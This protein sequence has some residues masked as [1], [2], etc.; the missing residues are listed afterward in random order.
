[1]S[2]PP[3]RI[4]LA[5]FD[6][7]G[8]IRASGGATACTTLGSALARAGHQV[9][10]VY[11]NGSHC[12]T[13][14]PESWKRHFAE[15]GIEFVPLEST[16]GVGLD[17]THYVTRSHHA[18]DWLKRREH[19]VVHFMDF[20]GLGYFSLRAKRQG[21]AFAQTRLCVSVHGPFRWTNATPILRFPD[22]QTLE[23]D[24]LERESIALA[25]ELFCPSRALVSWMRA[26]GWT[27]PERV[28]VQPNLLPDYARRAAP[29]ENGR[30]IGEVVF[31][32]RLEDVKGLPEFCDALDRLSDAGSTPDLKVTFLGKDGR[33]DGASG[34]AC[35]AR[36]AVHWTFP[37]RHVGDLDEARAVDYLR[38]PGRLAVIPSRRENSPYAVLECLAAGVPFLASRVGGVPELIARED[39]DRVTFAP[40]AKSMATKI[41]ECL[42]LGVAAARP[43]SDFDA[44]ER[45]WL[46]WHARAGDEP[47]RVAVAA[48]AIDPLASVCIVHHDRPELLDRLLR[49]VE[50]QDHPELE[51]VV[52]DDGSRMQESHRYLERLESRGDARFPL[53]V[54][55]QGNRYLGAAR[56]AA[57]R[58]A[59]GEFVVFMDDDDLMKPTMVSTLIGVARRTGA[60]VV[61]CACDKF[62]GAEPGATPRR[63]FVPLGAAVIVGLLKN[64][65]GPASFL[66]R[67]ERL[68]AV[69]GFT[70]DFGV[71]HEDWELLARVVLAGGRL[72]AVPE[73]LFWYRIG[74]A[75]MT[76]ATG[77]G[78][79]LRRNL[80]PYLAALP[81][82][83]RDLVAVAWGFMGEAERL[84]SVAPARA[85]QARGVGGSPPEPTPLVDAAS[86]LF[87]HG[88]LAHGIAVLEAAKSALLVRGD[89]ASADRV[90]SSIDQVRGL[91]LVGA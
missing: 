51:V 65:F 77:Y 15:Q 84:R 46:D 1:M 2:R 42:E 61:T 24:W 89:T 45:W 66:A 54:V 78:R 69:G 71:G 31:F 81:P 80:R 19:D 3:L 30:G 32:G 36:R 79:S 22:L 47:E 29:A 37:W 52:V 18:Y 40:D 83:F 7:L 28:H 58:A 57:M 87:E 43:A 72:E 41:H 85:P 10:L 73:P 26:E 90:Q 68:E 20:G 53:R 34:A 74:H 44:V 13:G 60:D 25:D 55:R 16:D 14:T 64:C 91:R 21:L 6:L 11:G 59:R 35:V 48:E 50:A 88:K 63:R 23:L 82:G 38:G 33:V 4:C 8:P 39:V 70:E 12:E 49:S 67:R 75:G 86:A 5:S 56:N 76:E 62:A 9:T 17:C 27:L